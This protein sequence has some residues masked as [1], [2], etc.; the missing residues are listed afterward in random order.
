MKTMFLKSCLL[1]QILL[2][3]AGNTRCS[4]QIRQPKLL[5]EDVMG[6]KLLSQGPGRDTINFGISVATTITNE[7]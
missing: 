1:M 4:S 7:S 3:L 2:A 5:R 6:K